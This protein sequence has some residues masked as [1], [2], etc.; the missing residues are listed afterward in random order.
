MSDGN[1]FYKLS[2]SQLPDVLA[3]MVRELDLEAS[4]ALFASFEAI[5]R[6]DFKWRVETQASCPPQVK[7]LWNE[8]N[9]PKAR[10]EDLLDAWREAYPM[11]AKVV[12]DFKTVLRWRHWLAHGRYWPQ[13]GFAGFDMRNVSTA[14]EALQNA[15]SDFPR[16][17]DW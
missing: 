9:G 16:L 3:E 13:K 15:I 8:V 14:A 1:Q 6:T 10:L 4:L 17:I 11:A 5:L 2:A 12:G 7:K